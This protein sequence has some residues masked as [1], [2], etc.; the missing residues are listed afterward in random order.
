MRDTR[1]AAFAEDAVAADLVQQYEARVAALER[2]VVPVANQS[3]WRLIV[4]WAMLLP[5]VGFV[6]TDL[7]NGDRPAA[8][9][10]C[11]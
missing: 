9:A 4:N 3:G 11:A 1:L 8:V 6:Q 2:L 10:S 7:W 5:D